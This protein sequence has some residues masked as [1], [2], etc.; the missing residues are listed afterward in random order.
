M[1][2]NKDLTLAL[3]IKALVEGLKEVTGLT[4][5]VKDLGTTASTPVADPTTEMRKGADQTSD[6]MVT[7]GKSLAGL[8]SVA[9]IQHFVHTSVDEFAKAESAFR[10]LEAVANFTGV[11][12]GRAM[13]EAEKL[14]ADGLLT[15]AD[16]SQSL[17]NLL[18]AGFNIDEAVKLLTVFKDFAAFNRR[19]GLSMGEAV[20]TAT[21]GVKNENSVLVDNVGLTKNL[22][23]MWKDYAASVG[24]TV[25]E[26]DKH[27]KV[28][29]TLNGSIAEGAAVTGNAAKALQGYQGQMAEADSAQRKFSA[30]MGQI[31]AP[32]MVGLAQIGT[33]LIDH[34]FKPFV[35]GIQQIAI[36]TASIGVQ[37]GIIYDAVANLDFDG[38]W[39]KLTAERQ[40]SF[41]AM[42]DLA[43]KMKSGDLDFQP[44]ATGA[45]KAAAA[46]TAS[47]AE[48]AK[49]VKQQAADR[50]ASTK[51]QIADYEK[52]KT[53][54]IKAFDESLKAEKNYRDQAKKLRAEA[55]ATPKDASAEGQ[56]LAT[57]GLIAAEQ[58]LQ[59]I[60]DKA[61]LEDVRAQAEL[62][63]NLA[64]GLDDQARAQEAVNR[65]KLAEADALDKAAAGEQVQ[66]AGIVEQQRLNDERLAKFSALL[67]DLESGKTVK[68]DADTAQADGALA[69]TKAG[70]DAITDKTVT[71][72]VRQNGGASGSFQNGATGA[73]ADGGQLPGYGGG[74]RIHILAE[75]GEAITRKEAVAYYGRSFMAALNA[76]QIPRFANGGIVG[77][78]A[79]ASTGGSGLHPVTLNMPGM[80]SWPMSA[81]A[82]VVAE[83][84]S[85]LALEALKH[86]RR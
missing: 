48:M 86:G 53:D 66:Q 85:A 41:A 57:L 76:R 19:A 4:K 32:V 78:L 46:T 54:L 61:P 28:T 13:Q 5:A 21:E 70:L 51:E 75:A 6:A 64:S 77:A 44:L 31:L 16:A 38:L 52:L 11:G 23:N 26:L 36:G 25:D 35:V 80:G 14:S 9:A 8:V 83:L 47:T 3:K 60:K 27:D 58:K 45:K 20:V 33:F 73:F 81:S 17:Q 71:V 72:T 62:V 49:A 12:I 63:R 22:S 65:S 18:S 7:L 34:L 1:A 40:R 74:D 2:N 79:S 29:A 43:K 42:D 15:V 69:Q 10:G 68:L 55:S 37:I 56:A 24:K 82:S 39:G 84:K 59:A 30:S 50:K 67:K